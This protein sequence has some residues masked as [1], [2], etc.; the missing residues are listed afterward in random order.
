MLDEIGKETRRI[1]TT[2][3]YERVNKIQNK[4]K[5]NNYMKFLK[6]FFDEQ[7]SSRFVQRFARVNLPVCSYHG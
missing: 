7:V 3:G 2:D 4:K 1:S 6:Y 5:Q